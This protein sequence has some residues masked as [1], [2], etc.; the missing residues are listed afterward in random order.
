[1]LMLCNSPSTVYR[2][3]YHEAWI[4]ASTSLKMVNELL[5]L[6]YFTLDN[7]LSLTPPSLSACA[8]ICYWLH[9]LR[10]L[11][12]PFIL[13]A[14][15]QISHIG[16]PA[17]Y[18]AIIALWILLYYPIDQSPVNSKAASTKDHSYSPLSTFLATI[19]TIRLDILWWN[20][21]G[22]VISVSVTT[23]LF[24][25]HMIIAWTTALYTINRYLIGTHVLPRNFSTTPH[26]LWD[27]RRLIYSNAQ[28]L[29]L[30]VLRIS[31]THRLR[32]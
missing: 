19:P 32:W 26:I 8:V 15:V 6:N 23:H 9:N 30:Y 1:M 4:R 16:L 28:S 2:L 14:P 25:P 18:P 24:L 7:I 3:G 10:N 5:L 29:L 13:S 27:F 11:L 31:K 12:E 21:S 20:P 17:T 22:T